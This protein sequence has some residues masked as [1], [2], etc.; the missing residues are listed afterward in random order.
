MAAVFT[1]IS[2]VSFGMCCYLLAYTR[3]Y[4]RAN[5]E[6]VARLDRLEG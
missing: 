3:K 6:I 5:A 2:F 1:V 4:M